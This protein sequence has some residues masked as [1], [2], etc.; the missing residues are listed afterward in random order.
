MSSQKKGSKSEKSPAQKKESK[1]EKKA[2]K[3]E[4]DKKGSK[5]EAEKKG[6]KSVST[7]EADKKRS[8][9]TSKKEA[10]K[11][12]SKSTSTKE[13]NKTISKKETD[14]KKSKSSSRKE[15]EKI[16]SKSTSTKEAD[17]KK[18][19]SISKRAADQKGSKSISKKEDEKSKQ[20]AP[21][22]ALTDDDE[23]MKAI[24]AFIMRFT[25]PINSK[26]EKNRKK[27]HSKKEPEKVTEAERSEAVSRIQATAHFMKWTVDVLTHYGACISEL[28]V[29]PLHELCTREKQGQS[30]VKKD[31][32]MLGKLTMETVNA[33][34]QLRN[35][36][37][38][39]HKWPTM[40]GNYTPVTKDRYLTIAEAAC[41][42]RLKQIVKILGSLVEVMGKFRE[43][44][45]GNMELLKKFCVKC[46]LIL[47]HMMRAFDAACT[48]AE[49]FGLDPKKFVKYV[50]PYVVPK[51][52]N[53][54]MLL[55]ILPD[56]HKYVKKLE[57]QI[58]YFRTAVYLSGKAMI[59]I[60]EH[61]LLYFQNHFVET[62][63]SQTKMILDQ[64]PG[65]FIY[66]EPFA[67]SPYA[68]NL[69]S[70]PPP[71]KYSL[72]ATREI[73]EMYSMADSGPSSAPSSMPT[74][75]DKK[76]QSSSRICTDR[77]QTTVEYTQIGD[78]SPSC[79]TA[80]GVKAL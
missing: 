4:A 33:G 60:C 70:K 46:A 9:S 76:T 21:S 56:A 50:S 65:Q 10:G 48:L 80:R 66:P 34:T 12:S 52:E 17:K 57:S 15:A 26:N 73:M 40:K 1:K 19:K 47:P 25:R 61:M 7:K 29:S 58:C 63:A 36:V 37:E 30:V 75:S 6:T 68:M 11:K 72:S 45:G 35:A 53:P 77:S 3:R 67:L 41:Y 32:D 59:D 44:I 55:Q 39:A 31:L 14:K 62:T 23:K 13:A 54:N 69:L 28:Y 78:E 24:L 43:W 74:Q 18:S 49:V 2:S 38:K 71:N 42:Y 16:K 51:P 20:S 79:K 22:K 27:Q 64:F 5:R 8:K